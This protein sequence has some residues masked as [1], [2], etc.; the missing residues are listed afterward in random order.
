MNPFPPSAPTGKSRLL[1]TVNLLLVGL[2]LVSSGSAA[3]P[4]ENTSRGRICFAL[5]TVHENTLKLTA[6]FYPIQNY[7]P[8]SAS[9]QLLEDGAWRTVQDARITY[10]GYT[11]HFRIEDWDDTREKSYRVA[12]AE[13]DYYTGTVRKNPVNR[14]EIVVAAFSCWSNVIEHGGQLPMNDIVDNMERLQPDL[15]FFAG[16][17]VYDHSNHLDNWLAFGEAFGDIIRNTPTITIPDDHDIGQGNL[18]GDGGRRSEDRNGQSGGYYMPV[19]YIREVERAQTS[20]L[21]DPYDPTPVERGIGVYYTSLTWGGISF[22]IVEDRKFKSGPQRVLTGKPYRD[23]REMD[24]P[25]AQLLGRRQLD[26]LEHWTTDWKDAE[27]KAV[28]SATI[29]ANLTTHTPT[30]E[31][32]TAFSYDSN[33]WPQSGRNRALSVIRKSFACMIAGDQ[34]L[35]SVIRHGIT[36]WNDAGYS[37]AVPAVANF[38]MRWWLPDEPGRHRQPGARE[39]T[40]EYEDGFHNKITV[41]AVANPSDTNN[42]VGEDPLH[43]RAAG[44]GVIR[45]SKAAREITYECWPRAVDMFAPGS[46][47]Y[48]GWPVTF[49]QTDN[50]AIFAGYELPTLQF[51]EPGEVETIQDEHTGEVISSLR[52]RG[53]SWQARVPQPGTYRAAVGE[54]ET[55]RYVYGLRAE[56]EN[57]QTITVR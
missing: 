22:A 38:W 28:L 13:R 9:L 25:E 21:P 36:D 37:F 24:V 8:F 56:R 6:Q 46:R 55:L 54:G 18:W 40:G 35:G 53:T 48:P 16:D 2:L 15:L 50:F 3:Q 12:Y 5:Y 32:R 51:T 23:T 47:P 44:Y 42:T 34:H 4:E 20:H 26:F 41:H 27:M 19:E 14:E 52:I 17:Q 11:A 7:E 45:F 43:G 29:F 31:N 10:P 39:Y 33:G 49:S 1:R 30:L 57:T